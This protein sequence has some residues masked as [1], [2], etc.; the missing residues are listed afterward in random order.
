MQKLKLPS[1]HIYVS[2][3]S[4]RQGFFSALSG[5]YVPVQKAYFNEWLKTKQEWWYLFGAISGNT[6]ELSPTYKHL[7]R[8]T[9]E[10]H[11]DITRPFLKEFLNQFN[12]L[13][14]FIHIFGIPNF[15]DP[16]AKAIINIIDILDGVYDRKGI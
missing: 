16:P 5:K 11:Y 8:V 1:T 9:P 10:E 6:I 12:N 15:P 3:I 14:S 4:N 2:G 7:V 13:E